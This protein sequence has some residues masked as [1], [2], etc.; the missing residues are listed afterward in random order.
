MAHVCHKRFTSSAAARA[1][2]DAHLGTQSGCDCVL[3]VGTYEATGEASQPLFTA[4]T[5]VVLLRREEAGTPL[6]HVLADEMQV[7]APG[8][9]ALLDRLL[10][11]LLS[12]ALATWCAGRHDE[13]PGWF[14]A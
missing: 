14:R 1:E 8:Q 10:D 13:A 9:R 7:D 3:L 11:L 6:L 2:N 5:D 4:R 12:S